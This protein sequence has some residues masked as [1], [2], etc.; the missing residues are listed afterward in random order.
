MSSRYALSNSP[1]RTTWYFR[2][3]VAIGCALAALQ[4]DALV[5]SH[6][7]GLPL[8]TLPGA[9]MAITLLCGWQPGL[10]SAA[11]F[12]SSGY[13]IPSMFP[14]NPAAMTILAVPAG[15]FLRRGLPPVPLVTALSLLELPE[16]L[17]TGQPHAI[18]VSI[19]RSTISTCIATAAFMVVP[20]RSTMFL[21]RRRIRWDHLTFM[22]MVGV[23]AATTIAFLAGLLR[24]SPGHPSPVWLAVSLACT[25]AASHLVA[26]RCQSVVQNLSGRFSGRTHDENGKKVRESHTPELP[27]DVMCLLFLVSATVSR[28]RRESRRWHTG[29]KQLRDGALRAQR[30]ITALR[31]TLKR[32]EADL[33]AS[34]GDARAVHAD[35][36]ALMDA[37]P[38][39][40]IF[41]DEKNVIRASNHI[42][43]ALLG[44]GSTALP[45]V[46]ANSL[47]PTEDMLDHP[48]E[49]GEHRVSAREAARTSCKIRHASGEILDVHVHVHEFMTGKKRNRPIVLWNAH[50]AQDSPEE[51]SPAGGAL[52][53]TNGA[54][55]IFV[56][57]M[58][59]EMRTP[60]HGLIATL[61]MM[62]SSESS[63][64]F[65]HQLSIARTS[66]RALLKIAN[67]V[68]D[69]S[70]IDSGLFKLDHQPF[71]MPRILKETVDE[72]RARAESR[73]LSVTANA[74]GILPPSFIG[75][76]ARL[77]QILANLVSNGLK[78]TTHGGISIT[79]SYRNGK[80]TIDVTDTGEGILPEKRESI[81]EPFVQLPS[82]VQQAVGGTGLGLPI[83]RKLAEAMGGRLVLLKSDLQGSTFRLDI[84]LE[85]S[86][87][88]PPDEQSQYVFRNPSGHILVVE[89][90]PANRYVARALLSGLGCRATIVEGGQEAL[91]L[92]HHHK[93]DLILMDCQLPLMDGYEATRRA[94]RI[95]DR[96]IPI[97]AMTANAMSDDRHACMEA[98]MDD[99]LPKP[100]DRRALSEILCK[101]LSPDGSRKPAARDPGKHAGTLPDLDARVLDDLWEGLQWKREPLEKI[102]AAFVRSVE[103]MLPLM[104]GGQEAPRP[105]LSRHIHALLGS[106]G[107]V[108]A[109]RIEYLAGHVHMLVKW[110]KYGQLA[111]VAR[112]LEQAARRYERQFDR[113]LEGR[114]KSRLAAAAGSAP[115]PRPK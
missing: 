24:F 103:Q 68:L 58:S 71:S 32:R 75:D 4:I 1:P 108:G 72:A 107:M 28:L 60:L 81:F 102:R 22:T 15:E 91:D 7:T 111:G 59:H 48:F 110:Q 112:S 38:H 31:D 113:W 76:P 17:Y 84:R 82:R 26:R 96:R 45:G 50:H 104:T 77:K 52:R 16:L 14:P 80:C 47:I 34:S 11:A 46:P 9:T 19:L 73:G 62:R 13:L 67:D 5:P 41:T 55:D 86:D 79:L 99:F 63:P 97:I 54:R 106:P 95:L 8:S 65:R 78:F 10:L 85:A 98:G 61:D 92:L 23:A 66:A 100:F 88:P 2:S 89:D 53:P 37:I 51:S 35:H 115:S 18:P 44:Y 90:N 105:A 109:R 43:A 56:A 93:F 36:D 64:D 21:P 94:R 25:L 74:T 12:V 69:L 3:L 30:E 42:A 49:M 39:G 87:A 70:R 40:A 83:C 29:F 27:R 114:E 33:H 20:I 6:V 101:W 57:T